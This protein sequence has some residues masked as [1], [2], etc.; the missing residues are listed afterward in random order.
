[1]TPSVRQPAGGVIL[2]SPEDL[3]G[4]LWQQPAVIAGQ[5]L[6]VEL[7]GQQAPASHVYCLEQESGPFQLEP[8]A[9]QV[10]WNGEPAPVSM[11]LML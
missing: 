10:A 7:T 9:L 6:T 11:R 3:T 8:H 4:G 5:M 1:M 2:K